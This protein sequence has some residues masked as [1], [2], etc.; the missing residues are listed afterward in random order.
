M[1]KVASITAVLV[2]AIALVVVLTRG[3]SGGG[4]NEAGAGGGE[5]FPQNVSAAGPAPF[6]RSTA[7]ATSASMSP[8]PL[9]SQTGTG[10]NT[11]QSVPGSAPGLYGGTHR[12]SSCDVEQQ[13]R[14]LAEEPPKNA[15]FAQVLGISANEVPGYLRSLTSVQLRVDT[16][17][18]NHGFKDGSPAPFQSVLQAGTAVMVDDH[19]VPR[20]RCA[21]GNPL[22]PPVAQKAPKQ[23]GAAWPGYRTDKVVVVQPS[24]TVINIFVIY[25]P[26]DDRWIARKPGDTGH[27]DRR[28]TPPP[29]PTTSPSA[30]PSTSAST[31]PST[32][33][34]TST[35][36][37]TPIPCVTVTG[38]QTPTPVDGVTPSPCPSPSVSTTSPSPSTSS[39]TPSSAPPP[40]PPTTG[41][42][43]QPAPLTTT[44]STSQSASQSASGTAT[45]SITAPVSP[46]GSRSTSVSPPLP[47]APGP[48]PIA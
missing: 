14:F 22:T 19:G 30:S 39:V 38:T 29:P 18:T 1:P 9:P 40:S 3:D 42:Q 28:T 34:S 27:H 17:V 46:S 12:T 10:A 4:K 45:A 2:A 23:V 16:R 33:P 7:R 36:P 13:I 35:S 25:D 41:P 26:H 21:C 48:Q 47:G 6:T 15:A 37:T 20:V 24:V 8:V 44:G 43:S 31:S 32:S 11:T 5:I